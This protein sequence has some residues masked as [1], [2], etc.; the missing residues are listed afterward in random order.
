MMR[1][2]RRLLDDPESAEA[3][4]LSSAFDEPPPRDL[5]ARTLEAAGAAATGTALAASGG[6]AKAGAAAA[7]KAAGSGILGAV[8]VGALAG[9]ITVGAVGL[10]TNRVEP[11]PVVRAVASAPAAPARA[12]A[13][14]TA[15]VAQTASATP[16]QEAHPPY[17]ATAPLGPPPSTLAAELSLLDEARAALREGQPARARAV[18]DRYEREIP[19]GQMA[20]EAALLRA[21]VDAAREE[22]RV[23]P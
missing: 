8:G 6:A 12:L 9:L 11:P 2:P 10:A 19:R 5:L 22:K 3:R 7:A 21:E 14:P 20:R 16:S 13:T 1:D 4:L 23:A 17:V 18:L 15:S